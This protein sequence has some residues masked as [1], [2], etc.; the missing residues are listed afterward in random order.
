MLWLLSGLLQ[1]VPELWRHVLLVGIA[2]LGV[3]RELGVVRI[4]LPQNA[5]QIARE[6][7]QRHVLR[8]AFQF[9]FELGTGVRTYVSATAPYVVAFAIL[10]AGLG[11][12]AALATGL[13]FGAGRALTTWSRYAARDSAAWDSWLAERIRSITVGIGLAILALCGLLVLF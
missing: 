13:G 1:P 4:R 6:V 10:L 12:P 3:L 9:G 11:F 2:L 7:L 5:R 8:G